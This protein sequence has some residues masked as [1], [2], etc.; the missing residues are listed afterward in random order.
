MVPGLSW[1]D[2]SSSTSLFHRSFQEQQSAQGAVVTTLGTQETFPDIPHIPDTSQVS[3][4]WNTTSEHPSSN[5]VPGAKL[6]ANKPSFWGF[7]LPEVR[8]VIH[9]TCVTSPINLGIFSLQTDCSSPL[10]YLLTF[11]ALFP[12]SLAYEKPQ[13]REVPEFFHL[14]YIQRLQFFFL[15]WTGH[16]MLK[17]CFK[18]NL[19]LK[20]KK[21]LPQKSRWLHRFVTQL[22]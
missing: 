1:G 12:L 8:R 5:P 19:L 11:L 14:I 7:L 13:N 21:W 18:I 17:D 15:Q 4:K 10:S 20:I 9:P 6:Q 3:L 22:C 16:T 2:F